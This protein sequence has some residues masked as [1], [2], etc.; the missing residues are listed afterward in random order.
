MI[1]DR[2]CIFYH[3][4]LYGGLQGFSN[5]AARFDSSRHRR[6]QG[7]EGAGGGLRPPPAPSSRTARLRAV[8]SEKTTFE[9]PW[10]G[11]TSKRLNGAD[12][13]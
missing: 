1:V 4:F 7:E 8:L 2:V 5:V 6:S 12:V 3:V 13:I 10:A 11:F 9:K